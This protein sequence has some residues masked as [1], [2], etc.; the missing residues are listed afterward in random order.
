MKGLPWIPAESNCLYLPPNRPLI[1]C[2]E[3]QKSN[4]PI[5][6]NWRTEKRD[7]LTGRNTDWHN[8]I[9]PFPKIAW[10]DSGHLHL[11]FVIF[12]DTKHQFHQRIQHMVMNFLLCQILAEQHVHF[13]L[14]TKEEHTAIYQL[15]YVK[16]LW[17]CNKLQDFC[18]S[19]FTKMWRQWQLSPYFGFS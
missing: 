4:Q 13:L 11:L 8:F 9:K 19:I 5:Q 7:R 14:R 2:K 15:I 17:F 6:R 18:K 16:F 3:C 10:Y 12:A 1:S